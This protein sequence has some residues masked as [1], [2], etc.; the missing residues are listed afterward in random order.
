MNISDIHCT[1]CG[2]P[3]DK[4]NKPRTM[5]CSHNIC[6]KCFNLNEKRIKCIYCNK[7][8]NS[9]A[10]QIF[11][12]NFLM[13]QISEKLQQEISVYLKTSFSLNHHY[14]CKECGI[15]FTRYSQHQKVFPS[16]SLIVCKAIENEAKYVMLKQSSEKLFKFYSQIYENFYNSIANYFHF[17]SELLMTKAT[18]DFSQYDIFTKL[19]L[20]GIINPAD[21][22]R[23][24][25]FN[26]LAQNKTFLSIVQCSNSY[27]DLISKLDDNKE[28]IGFTSSE[29]FALWFYHS[30]LHKT[31]LNYE[32]IQTKLSQLNE[33]IDK[34]D[35][36]LQN[37]YQSILDNTINDVQHIKS[38]RS[39]IYSYFL[40]NNTLYMYSI[41]YS[42]ITSHKLPQQLHSDF[43]V[44]YFSYDGKLYM[45]SNDLQSYCY[46]IIDQSLTR[47]PKF[48]L[49]K[50][51]YSLIICLGM[52]IAFGK[53]STEALELNNNDE[54]KEWKFLSAIDFNSTPVLI[55]LSYYQVYAIDDISTINK[56][57]VIKDKW[58]TIKIKDFSLMSVG[59]NSIINY[60]IIQHYDGFIIYGGYN[61]HLNQ[62]NDLI[63]E[64]DVT[65]KKVKLLGKNQ[66]ASSKDGLINVFINKE[67][68]YAFTYENEIIK[69][70]KMKSN[71]IMKIEFTNILLMSINDL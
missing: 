37:F 12:I 53:N 26:H 58:T 49:N 43:Y 11:P 15:K 9:K 40:I 13:L 34:D 64:M 21:K 61:M 50:V 28:A 23:L 54:K 38:T 41:V 27:E 7:Q 51:K 52:L 44:H 20:C 66:F 3:F 19:L 32:H 29:V 63:F 46:S 16:H 47:I 4:E 30:E 57:D 71:K 33:M 2:L 56:Y 24:V 1:F 5:P 8:Y 14:E 42:K 70:F 39:N 65:E 62:P 22:A 48:K 35:N 17:S 10:I 69:V 45:T 31:K 59:L 60:G 25:D 55:Q 36:Y 18:I 6:Q 68:L 67:D